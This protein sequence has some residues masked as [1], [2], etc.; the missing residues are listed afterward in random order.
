MQ[1]RRKSIVLKLLFFLTCF[2]YTFQI[3]HLTANTGKNDPKT[4]LKR[5]L[6]EHVQRS[7]VD[8]RFIFLGWK[9]L[10]FSKSPLTIIFPIVS[11]MH[12]VS[13]SLNLFLVVQ[14]LDLKETPLDFIFGV[15]SLIFKYL[16]LRL[17]EEPDKE[18]SEDGESEQCSQVIYSIIRRWRTR[19]MFSG[20]L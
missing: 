11:D 19:T 16:I 10:E 7:I 1:S 9:Y 15:N 20:N 13:N 12:N 18:E 2:S 8:R 17:G 4:N 14:Y 5:I 3:L 6:N